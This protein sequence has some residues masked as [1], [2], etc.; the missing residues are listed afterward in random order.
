MAQ[1]AELARADAGDSAAAAPREA[2]VEY[3][4]RLGDTA[5]IH[6]QRLSEWVR[7]APSIELDMALANFALDY[8]GQARMLLSYAGEVEGKGRGEDELAYFRD[9][10]DFRNVL[11]VELPRGDFAFTMVRLYLHASFAKGLYRALA[12]SADEQLAGIAQKAVKEV[13]YHCSHAGEWVVRLGDGTEE[14]HARTKAALAAAWPYVDELFAADAV[15]DSLAA[16]GIGVDPESLRADWDREV[17]ALL[18]RATLTRP[19]ESWQPGGGREGRHTEHLGYLL[20]EMQS[21]QRTY[22]GC[23]W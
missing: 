12:G 7:N 2:L 13:T 16:A 19:Q 1:A 6:A 11:L 10:W 23:E 3:C 21:V 4:L 5:L 20:A 22:P 18:A 15:E 8:V 9:A 17:E 14:S